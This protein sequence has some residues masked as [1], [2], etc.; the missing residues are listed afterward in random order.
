MDISI[1]VKFVQLSPKATFYKGGKYPLWRKL[2]F[3][4]RSADG[5]ECNAFN[6]DN[7]TAHFVHFDDNELVTPANA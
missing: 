7:G 4:V 6:D 5:T 2:S 3:P 1:R